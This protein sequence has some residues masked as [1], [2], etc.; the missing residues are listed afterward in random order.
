MLPRVRIAMA[1]K[2]N[3][4][5]LARKYEVVKTAAVEMTSQPLGPSISCVDITSFICGY[6]AHQETWLPHVGEVLLYEDGRERE[7]NWSS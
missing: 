5:T 2:R 7:K 1:S 4:L 6:H 3:D